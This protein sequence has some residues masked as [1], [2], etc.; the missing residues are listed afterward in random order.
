MRPPVVAPLDLKL[1]C[2]LADAG[3][4][5]VGEARFRQGVAQ[6]RKIPSIAMS[7]AHS[8]HLINHGHALIERLD[9]IPK[10]PQRF[11]KSGVVLNI[12]TEILLPIGQNKSQSAVGS[13]NTPAFAEE[14]RRLITLQV[15]KHML[16]MNVPHASIL[17]FE[18]IPQISEIGSRSRTHIHVD[19]TGHYAWATAQMQEQMAARYVPKPAAE[20]ETFRKSPKEPTVRGS[21]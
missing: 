1:G 20:S 10:M 11:K 12:G 21:C 2:D 16:T 9:S 3:E 8:E 14:A 6:F 18:R 17:Q 4:L 19:P 7:A 13:K 5:D 15:L